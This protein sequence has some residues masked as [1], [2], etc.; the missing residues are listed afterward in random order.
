MVKATA[1]H[2]EIERLQQVR[3]VGEMTARTVWAEPP[4][5]GRWPRGK[6]APARAGRPTRKKNSQRHGK[7]LIQQGAGAA[8][9]LH[10]RRHRRPAQPSAQ[11]FYERLRARRKPDKVA[12]VAVARRLIELLNLLLKP[13]NFILAG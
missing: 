9:A 4:E 7:R 2:A 5:L 3:G 11:A 10:G 1:G 6:P 13:P 8:R 12:L